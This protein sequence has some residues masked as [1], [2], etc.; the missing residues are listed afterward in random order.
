[1]NKYVL[2]LIVLVTVVLYLNMQCTNKINAGILPYFYDEKGKAYFLIGQ[3]PDG[4]W[5]DFGGRGEK[6]DKNA[7]KTALREF[8]EETRFVYGK[9]AQGLTCLEK[10]VDT[11]YLKASIKYIKPRITATLEHPKK[12][13]VMFLAK[14][15]FISSDVFSAADKVPHYEKKNYAWVPVDDFM[16]EIAQQSDRYNAYYCGKKIRRQIFDLLHAEHDIILKTIYP[17]HMKKRR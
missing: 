1:M 15:D 5:A 6:S 8:S 3:E 11:K 12:Y 7:R 10:G 16:K 2:Y 14:V 4:S 9:F 13:Y 17:K